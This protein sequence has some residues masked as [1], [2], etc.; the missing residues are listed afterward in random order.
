MLSSN[1]TVNGKNKNY[2]G[3]KNFFGRLMRT[4]SGNLRELSEPTFKRGGLRSTAGARL[5][6]TRNLSDINLDKTDLTK[7]Y[8]FVW[9]FLPVRS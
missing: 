3:I 1:N 8:M 2:K 4:S 5:E 6:A 9:I 7:R